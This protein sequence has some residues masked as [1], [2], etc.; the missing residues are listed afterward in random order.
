VL[1]DNSPLPVNVLA[2]ALARIPPMSL[3]DISN[4]L[5]NQ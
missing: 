2:A 5:A 4:V 3:S 1:I